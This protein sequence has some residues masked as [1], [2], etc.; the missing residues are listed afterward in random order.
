[1]PHE[2]SRGHYSKVWTSIDQLDCAIQQNIRLPYNKKIYL[3]DHNG[4]QLSLKQAIN[5]VIFVNI[6]EGRIYS[7][8]RFCYL[9]ML[10]LIGRWGGG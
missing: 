10:H 9:N 1:M 3:L 6:A 2:D 8:A 4:V 7:N 5:F